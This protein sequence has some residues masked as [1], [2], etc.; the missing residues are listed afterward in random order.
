ME[1]FVK[2]TLLYDFYGDLLTPHQKEIYE[3]YAL[4]DYSLGEIAEEKSISRQG[5]FDTV[6][7]CDKLLT[8]Y[9]AKLGLVDKFLKIQ[10]KVKTIES[11]AT[12]EEARQT[13]GDILE[14]L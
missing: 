7:R 13:A 9:E 8:E 1:S 2:H 10:E 4:E 3:A 6:K 11:A 14:L 5:V 12:L